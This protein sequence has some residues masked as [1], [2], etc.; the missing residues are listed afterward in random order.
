M[1][2]F[3][4]FSPR[5][6][7]PAKLRR[8]DAPELNT[9]ALAIILDSK[10]EVDLEFATAFTPEIIG[11]NEIMVSESIIKYLGIAPN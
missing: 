6:M 9:S 7:L 10:R 1:S 8:P 11:R 4:G 5:W 3:K 2:A